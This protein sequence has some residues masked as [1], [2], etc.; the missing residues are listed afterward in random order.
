MKFTDGLFQHVAEDVAKKYPDIEFE[1]KLI[2]NNVF[3][4]SLK[5]AH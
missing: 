1:H 4:C 3:F 5:P 2:D